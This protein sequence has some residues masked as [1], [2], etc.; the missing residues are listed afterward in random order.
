MNAGHGKT[1][2]AA[3]WKI[4][5]SRRFRFRF[6]SR[7]SRWCVET[8]SVSVPIYHIPMYII[9]VWHINIKL[10]GEQIQ[11]TLGKIYQNTK[12]N[13]WT[14]SESGLLNSP[15]FCTFG[16][17]SRHSGFHRYKV[18]SQGFLLPFFFQ[19]MNSSTSLALFW[20]CNH[21]ISDNVWR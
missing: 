18:M 2:H 10:L 12:C 19:N 3:N 11:E 4:N 13:P 15:L 5:N 17:I 14:I 1:L 6:G 20:I 21:Y 7:V 8:S 16:K 9:H